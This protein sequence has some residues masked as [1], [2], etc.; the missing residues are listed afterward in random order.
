MPQKTLETKRQAAVRRTAAIRAGAVR[1]PLREGPKWIARIGGEHCAALETTDPAKVLP[2]LLPLMPKHVKLTHVEIS[3]EGWFAI[4][5]PDDDGKYGG[6]LTVR[7]D[8]VIEVIVCLNTADANA[9]QPVWRPDSYE[10][11]ALDLMGQPLTQALERLGIPTPA[12]LFMSLTELS[13]ARMVAAFGTS[14]EHGYLTLEGFDSVQ[15]PEV[16][17]GT[18][19]EIAE[20]LQRVFEE[21]R[22]M[23]HGISLQ[24]LDCQI[25]LPVTCA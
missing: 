10:S 23:L 5:G 20:S 12:L 22:T 2:G 16:H 6:Y 1:L 13:G 7:R 11:C 25:D 19:R 21:V 3:S 14:R 4:P 15:F 18:D 8:G 9:R 24:S 17:V